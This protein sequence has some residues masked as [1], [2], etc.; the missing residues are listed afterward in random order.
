MK[1]RVLLQPGDTLGIVGGGQLARMLALEARR[2]EVR[3]AVQDPNPESPA[4]QV[5]DHFFQGAWSDAETAQR[6]AR[7]CAVVTVDNEHVPAP[8]LAQLQNATE[9]RPGPGV[10]ATIQDRLAQRRFLAELGIAQTPFRP[11]DTQEDLEA[12]LEE[13]GPRGVLKSRF[14]GYDGRGQATVDSATLGREPLAA[15]ELKLRVLE[16]FVDFEREVSVVLARAASGE[17]AY[18]PMVENEHH[19]HA[20]LLSHAPAKAETGLAE[21][22]RQVAGSIA[23]AL[24][25]I[26]VLAVE[27]FVTRSGELLVNE[28]A[29]RTHNS[30]HFTWDSCKC[31]QFEQHLR[32][33]AGWALADP[34]QHSP[35]AMLNLYGDLW[36]DGKPDFLPVLRHPGAKL[37]L[38]GKA[39]ARAGRKMGHVVVLGPTAELALQEA[40][41][42]YRQLARAK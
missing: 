41:S 8:L 34:G 4:A 20:L 1:P 7:S 31:S 28:V 15:G 3:V 6:M 26:G 40:K 33:V 27:F 18:F 37:H 23:N 14:H 22:A 12:G 38:Y 32:A 29:P 30:G 36:A 24:G 9:V 11:V 10:L 39:A 35:A 21:R 2:A 42:L 5:A 19:R 16:A 13:L 25:H 17:V